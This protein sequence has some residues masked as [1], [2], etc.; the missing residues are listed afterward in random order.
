VPVPSDETP[1]LA[2]ARAEVAAAERRILH[3]LACATDP[4]LEALKGAVPGLGEAE[5]ERRALAVR[6]ALV[7]RARRRADDS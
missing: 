1:E 5:R 4:E 7:G 2:S 3:R 6:C